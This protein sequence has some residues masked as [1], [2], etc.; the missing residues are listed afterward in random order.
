MIPKL[1][2]VTFDPSLKEHRAAVRAFMKR[3][4]WMDSPIKFRN[5]PNFGSVA[6][7]VQTKLLQ[8]YM[9]QEDVKEAKRLAAAALKPAGKEPKPKPTLHEVKKPDTTGIPRNLLK[10]A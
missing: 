1:E 8:W 4:A 9:E 10:Q 3:K 6:D 5:D 2:T 7:Q